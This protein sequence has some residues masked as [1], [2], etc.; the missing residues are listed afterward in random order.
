LSKSILKQKLIEAMDN[1]EDY[2]EDQIMKMIKDA[3]S[4]KSD[5]NDNSDMCNLQ[6]LALAY[7]DPDYE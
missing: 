5:T 6:G 4:T 2:S 1:I 7:M 3:A